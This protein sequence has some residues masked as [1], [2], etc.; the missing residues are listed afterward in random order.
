MLFEAQL[1]G[2]RGG[3]PLAHLSVDQLLNFPS[4]Y[5]TVHHDRRGQID[6]LYVAVNEFG[7]F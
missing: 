4:K 2:R 6:P 5:D 1:R 7:H 3:Y